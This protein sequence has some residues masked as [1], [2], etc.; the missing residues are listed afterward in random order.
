MVGIVPLVISGELSASRKAAA[1]RSDD[2]TEHYIIRLLSAL[3]LLKAIAKIS[4]KRN[5]KKINALQA[6]DPLETHES[7]KPVTI[8]T[9]TIL[10]YHCRLMYRT[11]SKLHPLR[12]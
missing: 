5:A 12:L 2:F 9:I 4:V 7:Q 11:Y 1:H 8:M 6:L 3:N 10:F